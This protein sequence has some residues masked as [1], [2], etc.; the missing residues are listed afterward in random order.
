MNILYLTFYFEPDLCAGSFRN[1]PLVKE[2]SGLLG[3][4]DRLH[5]LTTQPNRYRS[6]QVPAA[7]HELHQSSNGS[8]LIIERIAVPAHASGLRDQ[9]RSFSRYFRQVLKLTSRHQYDLVVA[10][11]SRLFT[12]FLG[13]R[14]ARKQ[15]IPLFLDVRDIFRES[16]LDVLTNPV[17]K[18]GLNPVLR[19]VE[20]YTFGY[21]GHINLVS[22]GF[23]PYFQ[24]YPQA[25]YTFFTNGIDEAF[26][27]AGEDRPRQPGAPYTIVYAGNIG[28]G[29]GLHKIIPRAARELG[30]DFRFVLVGDGGARQKLQAALEAVGADN[31]EFRKPVGREALIDLYRKAD[32]LF[33]HLNDLNAFERVL[34]SKI[35]EYA[36]TDKP[37]L[38]GVAG[39]AR[40]FIRRHVDHCLLFD[41]GDADTLV[42]RLK[43]FPPTR[44]SREA[45]RQRFQRKSIVRR[46]ALE[47]LRQT[48]HPAPEAET[49]HSF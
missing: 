17:V 8:S 38:A 4:G 27:S 37:I 5:V 10:S 19:A 48:G 16:V 36:S 6:F 44:C 23:R 41:P 46:M 49:T 47:I 39:Y 31:V 3:R 34:P 33:L 12:A 30:K 21:A 18:W 32:Y 29:Q 42:R 40:H 28:E 2:L 13:A 1:T 35:F 22:E 25:T 45:F 7:A 9:V 20:R 26:L 11:S 15:R 43:E 14:I 24:D